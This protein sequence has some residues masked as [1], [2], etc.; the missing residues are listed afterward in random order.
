MCVCEFVSCL[1][2]D[3]SLCVYVF[4][5]VYF[6]CVCVCE[7]VSCLCGNVSLSKNLVYVCVCVCVVTVVF[8]D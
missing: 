2:V 4:A 3:V 1:Y 5:H 7:F 8:V 6:T